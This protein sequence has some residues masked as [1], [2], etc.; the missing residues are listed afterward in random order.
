MRC[1]GSTNVA[2]SKGDQ[3]VGLRGAAAQANLERCACGLLEHCD[4]VCPGQRSSRVPRDSIDDFTTLYTRLCGRGAG[5]VDS[6][7][8]HI[9]AQFAD[10]KARV[11]SSAAT[12]TSAPI[13]FRAFGRCPA[14]AP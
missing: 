5:Y 10:W 6:D 4:Y 12:S 14:A 3:P 11:V 8:L 9:F 2:Q 7:S 1:E 13:W